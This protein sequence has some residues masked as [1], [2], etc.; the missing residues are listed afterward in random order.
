MKLTNVNGTSIAVLCA[1]VAI[2]LTAAV[3]FP[4]LS[5]DFV[6]WDDPVDLLDNDTVKSLSIT[7][8]KK[9]FTEEH[10][11]YFCPLVPLSY[12]IE[13][14]FFGL[15]PFVYHLTNYILNLLCVAMVFLFI[16]KLTQKVLPAFITAIFFGVHPM[17]VESVAWVAERKD[18]LCAVFY[19]A[20]L[21]FYT[22]YLSREEKRYYIYCL[23]A[24]VLAFMSKPMAVTLPFILLLLD[25]Y[26]GRAIKGKA[27][28]EKAPLFALAAATVPVTIYFQQVRETLHYGTLT[29]GAKGYFLSKVLFFYLWKLAV[30]LNLSVL[31]PYHNVGPGHLAEIKYYVLFLAFVVFLV[32]YSMKYT[33]KIVFGAVFFLVTI[34]P[35]LKIVG[36]GSV[37]AAD[38][39]VYLPSIGIFFILGI[40]V[41]RLTRGNSV[42]W[43]IARYSAGCFILLW[44]AA[45]SVLT[46][47]RCEVW[48]NTG[49]LFMDAARKY[50]G[51]ATP[52]NNIG[53]Y[54]LNKGE[55][56]EAAGYFRRALEVSPGHRNAIDN[57]MLVLE[58]KRE[59][60]ESTLPPTR[61][62]LENIE[63]IAREIEFLNETGKRQGTA[64]NYDAAIGLFNR[65]VELDPNY[66]ETYNNLGYVYFIKGDMDFAEEYFKK[67]L[68]A[69]PGHESARANLEIVARQKKIMKVNDLNARGIRKGLEGDMDGAAVLFEEAIAVDPAN[70]E[71]YNNM[72]YLYSLKED[73]ARAESYFKKAL[74]MDP[75]HARAGAN[76]AE[77]SRLRRLKTAVALNEQGREKGIAGDIDGAILLFEKAVEA[78]PG[79][80]DTYNNLGYEYYLKGD[81]AAAESY[82]RK[83][84]EL[85]PYHAGA[86]T[87]LRM[88]TEEPA[89]TESIKD[90]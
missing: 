32:V 75:A 44:V 47:K 84:L 64:G 37:F 24:G 69:D 1:A 66:A 73:Y 21:I 51:I 11:G 39:Y 42:Q 52:Y 17:H 55:Y 36:M 74:E 10:G 46:W 78:A 23:A 41:D 3:F 53:V 27:I 35:V 4:S 88:V 8:I 68:E 71:S 77:V 33:R 20:A 45:L 83:A 26:R 58:L 76:L 12:A 57:L 59:A 5:N 90:E 81:G 14:R 30:P 61:A 87:N 72:G 63:D 62:Q 67:A 16:Y 18:L 2:I 82:F 86:E 49:T 6:G 9:M 48:E 15:N 40:L 25:Y 31:Y 50:P 56:D 7:N 80:A 22:L 43:T 85:D 34:L 79:Y 29:L 65:A 89:T 28:V 19:L 13:Y 60:R 54:L 70:A 38:R